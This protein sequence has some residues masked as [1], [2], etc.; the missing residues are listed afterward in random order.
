MSS[1]WVD[2]LNADVYRLRGRYVTRVVEAGEGEPLLLLHGTGGH[3]E[4]YARNIAQFAKHFRVL[5]IDFLWHG[6]SQTTGFDPEV[7]PT[8]VDQVLDVLDTLKIK[9]VH[10]E[11]QSLGGWV[12]MLF[13]IKYPERVSK[14]VVTTPMGYDPDPGSVP[15]YKEQDIDKLRDSSLAVLREP[16]FENVRVRMARIL[17]DPS[18]LTDEAIAVRHAF[19]NDPAVN[20]VQQEF[21]STYFGGEG[22][23]RYRITDDIA[24]CIQAPT[25]VYW[26]EENPAPPAVG[27][28]LASRIPGGRFFCAEN[29]GHWA[30]FENHE[31][32]NRE[33][34]GF[35]K[36]EQT[37]AG[38]RAAAL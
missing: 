21:I 24:A 36:Q 35:L 4:N 15:T 6:R 26:G 32:H 28:R 20:A 8:L 2:L 27:E 30:Q 23:R 25:L 22:P 17:A 31:I 29:T 38:Q 9:R 3:A 19:Y 5:A 14:L 11:G 33:V 37:R 16:S 34:L 1:Y 13:A 10:L 18:I 12:A 7:M